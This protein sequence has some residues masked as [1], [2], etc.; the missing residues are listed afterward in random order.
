MCLNV[1]YL[2]NMKCKLDLLYIALSD[3]N[4]IYYV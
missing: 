2:C 1:K 4:D 3:N